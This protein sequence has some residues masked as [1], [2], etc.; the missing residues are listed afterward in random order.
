MFSMRISPEAKIGI[1]S[2][3]SFGVGVMVMNTVGGL[4]DAASVAAVFG[5]TFVAHVA[6]SL[7]LGRF[8]RNRE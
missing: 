4:R 1:A 3:L 2:G 8:A 7:W 5:S 6:F